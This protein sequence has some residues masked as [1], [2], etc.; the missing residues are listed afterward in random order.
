MCETIS[1]VQE[2]DN[3]HSSFVVVSVA[4]GK[5]DNEGQLRRLKGKVLKKEEKREREKEKIK[6]IYG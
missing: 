5:E 6:L 2:P 3:T 4:L 1:E